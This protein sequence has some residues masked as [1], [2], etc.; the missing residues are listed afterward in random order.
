MAGDRGL[1]SGEMTKEVKIS[2]TF[3]NICLKLSQ[4]SELADTFSKNCK[5]T[6][7]PTP[8]SRNH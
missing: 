8:D 2:V 3:G 4:K 6:K 7:T 1:P 5:N